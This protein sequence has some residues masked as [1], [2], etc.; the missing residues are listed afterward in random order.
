[1]Y[2]H[3][4]FQ[5]LSTRREVRQKDSG[6]TRIV[7]DLVAEL[8]FVY[9]ALG[10]PADPDELV[11]ACTFERNSATDGRLGLLTSWVGAADAQRAVVQRPSGSSSERGPLTPVESLMLPSR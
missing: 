7:Y 11:I 3:D 5:T 6:S 1:L 2:R 10:L 4:R 8:S 9:Q